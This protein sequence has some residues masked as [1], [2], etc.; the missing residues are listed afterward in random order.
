MKTAS[1][2]CLTHSLPG[3][4]S[5]LC[6]GRIGSGRFFGSEHRRK[7]K[8]GDIKTRNLYTKQKLIVLRVQW[9]QFRWSFIDNY[10]TQRLL[11]SLT[12]LLT[13]PINWRSVKRD[14]SISPIYWLLAVNE[15]I[16]G[17]AIS[18][19][20]SMKCFN[21][22]QNNQSWFHSLSCFLNDMLFRWRRSKI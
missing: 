6:Q 19:K 8:L 5:R 3:G 17:F 2:V 13:S 4:L 14:H 1:D 7:K 15:L 10:D 20:M 9:Y 21:I 12:I 16:K 22:K 11:T 18:N